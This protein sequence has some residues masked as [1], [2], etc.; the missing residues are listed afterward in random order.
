MVLPSCQVG[1]VLLKGGVF[2]VFFA[3]VFRAHKNCKSHTH[4]P[5]ARSTVFQH[6]NHHHCS[7]LAAHRSTV[8]ACRNRVADYK[9][10]AIDS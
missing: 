5:N 1:C 10:T 3:L 4:H 8:R 6:I 9:S 2:P 7:A